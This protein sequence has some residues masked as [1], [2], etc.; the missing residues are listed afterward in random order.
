M[1]IYRS[2]FGVTT[3]VT[4]N[5]NDIPVALPQQV[6]PSVPTLPK[7]SQD[8]QDLID[9][10]NNIWDNKN[11]SQ[12]QID[13]GRA[14]ENVTQA[15]SDALRAV[16][17]STTLDLNAR[18]KVEAEIARIYGGEPPKVSDRLSVLP[19]F[20]EKPVRT[21]LDKTLEF[22]G[23]VVGT[24]AALF[25]LPL[26]RLATSETS[27]AMELSSLRTKISLVLLI[28][29]SSRLILIGLLQT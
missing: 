13:M 23:D 8:E 6:A 7:R 26:K 22:A 3:Q 5:N 21:G 14:R 9:R 1:A 25:S 12:S 16:G 28:S 10:L 11:I 19:D 24:P 27:I 18:Q 29:F 20:L 15:E 2:P 17:G 4:P